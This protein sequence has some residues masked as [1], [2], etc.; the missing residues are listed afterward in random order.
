MK[1]LSYFQ[2]SWLAVFFIL[3]LTSQICREYRV[4]G[5]RAFPAEGVLSKKILSDAFRAAL[6]A[7][8]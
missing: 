6:E 2:H 7:S 5:L 1:T 8:L 3:F 4:T